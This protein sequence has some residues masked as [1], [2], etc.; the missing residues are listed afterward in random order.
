MPRILLIPVLLLSLATGVG[1]HQDLASRDSGH[2]NPGNPLPARVSNREAIAKLL[3]PDVHL[4]TV[5]DCE[6][7]GANK[8]TV[9]EEL[10][11][12]KAQIGADGKLTDAAGKPI[13]FFRL[14]GCWGNP[15]A[16]YLQILAEQNRRLEELRKTH[17][18]ITLTCNPSGQLIP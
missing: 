5:A 18:V 3:P 2:T 13:E 16:N 14:G 1:C 11:R 4:D 7:G 10:I 6:I 15:P 17:T 12:A 9:E 8:V